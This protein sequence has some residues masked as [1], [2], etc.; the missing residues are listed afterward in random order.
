MER[1]ASNNQNANGMNGS[2][3]DYFGESSRAKNT[4]LS[5]NVRTLKINERASPI[6]FRQSEQHQLSRHMQNNQQIYKSKSG[7]S[8]RDLQKRHES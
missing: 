8:I 3:C 1:S 2:A 5:E 6:P 7:Q 4:S